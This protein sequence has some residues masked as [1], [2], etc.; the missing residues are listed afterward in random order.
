MMIYLNGENYRTIDDDIITV[1]NACLDLS[2]MLPS[3][4]VFLSYDNAQGYDQFRD[5]YVIKSVR[6]KHGE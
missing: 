4:N 1:R 6:Y 2:M 3:V 5:G